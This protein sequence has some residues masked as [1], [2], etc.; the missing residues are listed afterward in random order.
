MQR[1]TRDVEKKTTK[2]KRDKEGENI[3]IAKSPFFCI[4]VRNKEIRGGRFWKGL[5]TGLER[6]TLNLAASQT[7]SLAGRKAFPKGLRRNLKPPTK[8][9]ADVLN[10]MQL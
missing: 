8:M 2:E 1:R 3:K 6:E 10:E 9:V 4:W 7:P 5:L